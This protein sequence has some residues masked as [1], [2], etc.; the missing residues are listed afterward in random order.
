MIP[1]E[2]EPDIGPP[3]EACCFCRKRTKFWTMLASRTPG[4]QV[5][6][7]EACAK[8]AKPEDVP[9]KSVWTRRER[10]ANPRGF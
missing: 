1:I 10:I 5:A 6:C 7:C 2:K 4:Q 9:A 3:L 8:E